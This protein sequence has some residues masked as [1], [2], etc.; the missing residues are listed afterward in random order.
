MSDITTSATIQR[1]R[2]LLD[3]AVARQ[4]L[5]HTVADILHACSWLTEIVEQQQAMIERLESRISQ[6]EAT[7]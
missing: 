2:D 6:L 3:T 7:K 4:M 5:G 1:A